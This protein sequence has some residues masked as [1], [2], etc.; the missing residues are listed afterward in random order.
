MRSFILTIVIGAA[1]W[2]WLNGLKTRE[3]A[4]IIGKAA[5][6]SAAVQFLDGSVVISKIGLGRSKKGSLTLQRVYA[7]EF[8]ISGE[9]RYQG[10]I[11]MQGDTV[12][13]VYLDHPDGALILQPGEF[14]E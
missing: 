7:F 5:A 12:S 4:T 13:N 3:K 14:E 2:F 9:D 6:K 1:V 11:A 10:Q 8:S